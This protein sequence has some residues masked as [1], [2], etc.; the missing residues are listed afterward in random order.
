MVWTFARMVQARHVRV[1]PSD[2]H[3]QAVPRSD[4]NPG[5]PLR[6]ELLGCEPG[7]GWAGGGRD[8]SGQEGRA[9]ALSH[10][11]YPTVS[12]PGSTPVPRGWAPLCWWQVC[13]QGGP[14]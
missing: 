2:G 11:P 1:W 10:S 5:G 14:M 4:A 8:G 12:P 13:P 7:T 9:G 3:H 6:V